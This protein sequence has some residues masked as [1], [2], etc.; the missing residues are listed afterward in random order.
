LVGP[1]DANEIRQ[2]QRASEVKSLAKRA[3]RKVPK[4]VVFQWKTTEGLSV[5][6]LGLMEKFRQHPYLR[7]Q[8]LFTGD[9]IL[10]EADKFDKIWAAGLEHDDLIKWFKE[11]K[12]ETVSYP[13]TVE[14]NTIEFF[15]NI[16]TGK[17]L[18]GWLLQY[19]RTCLRLEMGLSS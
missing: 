8:L 11:H 1:K 17:N 19:V 15:P 3:L 18:L 16:G 5:M 2:A 7:E 13:A 6:R 10:A 14:P 4:N 12:G 9:K